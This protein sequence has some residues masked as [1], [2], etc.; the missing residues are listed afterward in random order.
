MGYD[1]GATVAGDSLAELLNSVQQH[2][3]EHHGYRQEEIESPEK[4]A[5]WEGAIK[6]SSRPGEIR[7]PRSDMN[8][9]TTPH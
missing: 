1:C 6:Q 4:I 5:I 8:P 9:G 7:T 3:L 2:A